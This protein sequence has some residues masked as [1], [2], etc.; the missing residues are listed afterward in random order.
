MTK[1]EFEQLQA[2]I[3]ECRNE[4][5][6]ELG[7]LRKSIDANNGLIALQGKPVE[8]TINNGRKK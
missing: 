4:T 1:T 8:I 7:Q 5:M 2:L 3:N 6:R